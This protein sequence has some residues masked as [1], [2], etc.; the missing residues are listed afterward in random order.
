MKWFNDKPQPKPRQTFPFVTEFGS[1]KIIVTG[2]H[3]SGRAYETNG[4]GFIPLYCVPVV[5]V[6]QEMPHICTEST[7][8]ESQPKKALRKTGFF[9]RGPNAARRAAMSRNNLT[10][11]Y[12]DWLA[13]NIRQT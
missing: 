10:R 3:Y 8:I 9:T 1:R 11:V 2:L 7:T 4:Y 13:A 12:R 6:V 5:E